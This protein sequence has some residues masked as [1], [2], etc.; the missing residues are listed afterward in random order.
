MPIPMPIGSPALALTLAPPPIPIVSP[1]LAIPIASL[2][3][4]VAITALTTRPV[5][6]VQ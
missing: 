3:V 5:A 6:L 4:D 2:P 1:P